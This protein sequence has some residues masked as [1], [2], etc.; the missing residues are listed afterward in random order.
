M[1]EQNVFYTLRVLMIQGI[2]KLS[3]G[4]ANICSSA[5]DHRQNFEIINR[6]WKKKREQS[7]QQKGSL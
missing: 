4:Y 3:I 6:F 2:K 7:N 5:Q 1:L